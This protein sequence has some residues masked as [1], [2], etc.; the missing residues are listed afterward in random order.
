MLIPMAV[1]E[2][3]EESSNNIDP[4]FTISSNS[5]N[6]SIAKQLVSPFPRTVYFSKCDHSCI[7]YISNITLDTWYY[8]EKCVTFR[9]ISEIHY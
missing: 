9:R 6:V 2:E 3:E 5:G 1:E 4:I 8:C 7:S